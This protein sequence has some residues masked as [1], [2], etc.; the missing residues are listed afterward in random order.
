MTLFSIP[1]L[2]STQVERITFSDF[3]RFNRPEFA[4]KD[5]YRRWCRDRSTRHAFV[6]LVE[7]EIPNVR[8]SATNP[9][10]AVHGIVAEYDARPP[11][12][13]LSTIR[14][15]APE[16]M[17]P[18]FL[19]RSFSGHV[20]LFYPF[21]RPVAWVSSK[22]WAEFARMTFQ[23]LKLSRLLPGFSEDESSDAGHY[24]EIGDGWKE[25]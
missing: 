22:F 13:I 20:R 18:R 24:Y 25:I 6:S 19:C 12:D 23:E 8:V 16:G 1:S 2:V 3:G 14:T 10:K 21:E 5:A 17:L 4:D 15:N 7:G 11:E 9:A